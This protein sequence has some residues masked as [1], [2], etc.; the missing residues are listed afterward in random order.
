MNLLEKQEIYWKQRAK[1][2]WLQEGDCNTRFFHKFASRRR[3]SNG[4]YRIKDA[5]G[6]WRETKQEVRGVVEE[7]FSKLFAS[8]SEGG[9]LSNREYVRQISDQENDELI[10]DITEDEVKNAVFSMHPDKSPGPDGFN[11][12][13][14]QT[15]WKV[16][17]ADVVRFCQEFMRSG[18]LPGNSNH[19]IVCLIPKVKVPQVMGDLRPISL[20]NVLVRILSKVLS[21]RLK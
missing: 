10:A 19:S 13:F 4:V 11:P 15:F 3:R 7:Y 16:V 1:N 9:D 8:S 2:F 14:F 21:I 6:V 20:C 18:R 12:A 5:D 17:C